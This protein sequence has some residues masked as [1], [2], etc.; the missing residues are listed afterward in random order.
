[1]SNIAKI[2]LGSNDVTNIYFGGYQTKNGIR[3]LYT[4][5]CWNVKVGDNAV[6]SKEKTVENCWMKWCGAT[7]NSYKQLVVNGTKPN[8]SGTETVSTAATTYTPTVVDWK[9]YCYGQDGAT[10]VQSSVII[11]LNGKQ[12]NKDLVRAIV[13][14][15]LYTAAVSNSAMS[16]YYLMTDLAG[17]TIDFVYTGS[18]I[19]QN[20]FRNCSINTINLKG[21]TT[22]STVNSFRDTFIGCN[23]QTITSDRTFKPFY[24]SG[25]FS[26]GSFAPWD[27]AMFDYTNVSEVQYMFDGGTVKSVPMYSGAADR[28][29]ASNTIDC[30]QYADQMIWNGS[31]TYFG[32]VVNC[33]N[34]TNRY[35]MFVADILTDIRIKNLNNGDWYFDDTNASKGG[36]LPNLDADS[37]KYLFDNLMDLTTYDESL[38]SHTGKAGVASAE[39]HCPAKWQTTYNAVD[40]NDFSDLVTAANA[41]NWTVFVGGSEV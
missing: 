19:L 15:Q 33:V 11:R 26:G 17:E 10:P 23:V 34:V 37:I 24:L 41:K 1:M 30:Y 6:Y 31:M 32:P 7:I 14:Y 16:L 22:A 20:T 40:G 21:A 28:E 5:E 36:Y 9:D 8:S 38:T 4:Q 35:R 18:V 25:A 39:L 27:A 3:H 29:D 12:N 13:D 2:K